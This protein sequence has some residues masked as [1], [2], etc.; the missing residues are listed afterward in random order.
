[1]SIDPDVAL[2]IL[3]LSEGV[4]PAPG[5]TKFTRTCQD[6]VQQRISECIAIQE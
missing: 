5:V 2:M 3:V 6:L 1:V 4:S